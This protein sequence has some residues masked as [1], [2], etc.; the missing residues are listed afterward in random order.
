L[1]DREEIRALILQVM[2]KL[3]PSDEDMVAILNDCLKNPAGGQYPAIPFIKFYEWWRKSH[4][5]RDVRND[6]MLVVETIE[7]RKL[8]GWT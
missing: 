2:T 3:P 6:Q 7:E 5:G 1:L 8:K 4:V